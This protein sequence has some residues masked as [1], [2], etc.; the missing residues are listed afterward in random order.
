M[1]DAYDNPVIVDNLL[2]LSDIDSILIGPLAK[3]ESQITQKISTIV[4]KPGTGTYEFIFKIITSGIYQVY[5]RVESL[6]IATYP[7]EIEAVSNKALA[8]NSYVYETPLV[9]SVAGR[10]IKLTLYILDEFNNLSIDENIPVDAKMVLNELV[11]YTAVIT[12]QSTGI[13]KLAL[14]P[15]VRGDYSMQI[16]IFDQTETYGYIKNMP[17]KQVVYP[18]FIAIDKTTYAGSGLVSGRFG[19]IET[20]ILQLRDKY[21]NSYNKEYI[22]YEGVNNRVFKVEYLADDIDPKT[23]L[24]TSADP[25]NGL[26]ELGYRIV[27]AYTQ[28]YIRIWLFITEDE[29]V[30]FAYKPIIDFPLIVPI[31][32]SPADLLNEYSN[33][34]QGGIGITERTSASITNSVVAG[35]G[36]TKFMEVYPKNAYDLDYIHDEDRDYLLIDYINYSDPSDYCLCEK[37][38]AFNKQK[39]WQAY[40][41]VTSLSYSLKNCNRF[42]FSKDACNSF[43][44][45]NWEALASKTQNFH[46]T[47]CSPRI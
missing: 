29:G 26:Y 31:V 34:Y 7:L 20:F 27:N 23:V 9:P 41:N 14:T 33:L 24:Q 42:S 25:T 18:D 11:S 2:S 6:Q 38:S 5:T 13:Y 19:F 12:K 21:E 43:G 45:C 1:Y 8:A 3:P 44:I 15:S 37:V 39:L 10:E 17:Q 46:E 16:K 40:N 28:L 30:S 36:L 32:F 47:D 35:S 4:Q 22:F